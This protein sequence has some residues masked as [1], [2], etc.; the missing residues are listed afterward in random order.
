MVDPLHTRSLPGAL[1]EK[2]PKEWIEWDENLQDRISQGI[3]PLQSP[4]KE[5]RWLSENP[6]GLGLVFT[7]LF[8]FLWRPLREKVRLAERRGWRNL[9]LFI[10]FL[11]LS[12]SFSNLIKRIVGRLKPHVNF[13]N[14]F[15]LPALSLP[16]NHAFNSAFLWTL[17]YFSLARPARRNYRHLFV[18]GLGIV[19]LIGFSRVLFGQH[20]PLDVI[21]GFILGGLMGSLAAQLFRRLIARP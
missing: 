16:S 4:W 18:G 9:L 17:L 3:D 10:F 15:F 19:L 7:L 14:T 20:Y 2:I 1:W 13:Y 11:A 12:D 8:I 21:V 6:W 5:L